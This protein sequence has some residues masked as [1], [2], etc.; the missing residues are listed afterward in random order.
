MIRQWLVL[1]PVPYEGRDGAKALDQEQIPQEAGLRVQTGDRVKAGTNSMVWS[2]IQLE[3][4][5]MDFVDLLG[6][7]TNFSVA[8][9]LCY[10]HCQ[11]NL[12]GL[13]MKVGSDDG[14]KIYLNG[15][16]IYRHHVTRPCVPDQDV[17]GGVELKAGSNV[18]LFKVVNE[19]GSWAGSVRLTD[20]AGRSVKGI[21]VTLTP[22]NRPDL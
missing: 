20:A 4:H 18:L 3:D 7:E 8:Y 16:E 1:A 12:S 6:E 15:T 21:R 13:L 19:T 22:S 5:L 2:A 10:I 14:A 11:T 9:A 17:V